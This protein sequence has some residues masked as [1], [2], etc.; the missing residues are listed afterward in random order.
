VG[1][2]KRPPDENHDVRDD[3]SAVRGAQVLKF[4]TLVEDL[5]LERNAS[6]ER[7]G[8]VNSSTSL[9]RIHDFSL[10]TTVN[11]SVPYTPSGWLGR[12]QTRKERLHPAFADGA[13]P[14]VALLE[15]GRVSDPSEDSGATVE[16]VA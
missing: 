6:L 10:N 12:Y 3:N 14:G 13:T 9:L 2:S 1:C 5:S 15:N 4:C 7:S 11:L 8:T 16:G